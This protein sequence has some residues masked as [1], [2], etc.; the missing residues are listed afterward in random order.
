MKRIALLG[1][2]S[3]FPPHL[4]T[5]LCERAEELP[6]LEVRLHGPAAAAAGACERLA[7]SRGAAH[8]YRAASAAEEAITGAD[9]VVNQADG[10]EDGPGGGPVR[11]GAPGELGAAV[12]AAPLAR[13]LAETT[14][15]YAPR[16]WFLQRANPMSILL[17]TLRDL[18]GLRAF[19]LCV[20]PGETLRRA[21][22]VVGTTRAEV[23]VDYF[24]LNRRGF[25]HRIVRRGENLLPAL[26]AALSG[27]PP[28]YLPGLEA[29]GA[30]DALPLCDE[31]DLC[32]PGWFV[33]TLAPAIVALCGGPC[34]ELYVSERNQGHVGALPY[35]AI[36]EKRARIDAFGATGERPLTPPPEALVERVQAYHR[37]EELAAACARS[38]GE[39]AALEALLAHPSGPGPAVARALVPQVLAPQP[40][41]T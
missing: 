9:L 27:L 10:S 28:G 32:G 31:L 39:E 12:R 1:G 25:F 5:A 26:A 11:P 19:G 22:T 7:R 15:R 23:Q 30:L 29:A 3:S 40:V 41:S 2:P 14:L 16:A 33:Q 8:R 21:L 20:L 24:G 6:E 13:E 4:A 36:V 18:D 37:F 35:D 38:P 34:A 17:A